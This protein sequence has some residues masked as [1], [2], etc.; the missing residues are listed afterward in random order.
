MKYISHKGGILHL[1]LALLLWVYGNGHVW[2]GSNRAT[3]AASPMFTL[4]IDAGHGGKDPGAIGKT[5][6]EKNINLSVALALGRLVEQ[7]CPDVRVVYT[8]KTDVFVPLDRR[9]EIANKAKADLFLSIHTNALPAGNRARGAETYTLGMARAAA[10]LEVAKRENAAILI[11]NDYEARY[12]GFDPKS[13]ESYIIFEF[14]QDKNMEQSVKLARYIQQEFRST[15]GRPDKGVHQAGFL[16]LRATSM[17]SALIELG[18]ISTPDEERYLNSAEGV[19]QMSRSIY[20]AFLKY[21]QNQKKGRTP[22]LTDSRKTNKRDGRNSSTVADTANPKEREPVDTPPQTNEPA[23][24][25]EHTPPNT[26]DGAQ[27][28]THDGEKNSGLPTT[29]NEPPV[30]KVQILTCDHK[31]PATDKRFKGLTGIEHYREKNLYK[32]TWGATTDYAECQRRRK[33]VND[34]FPDAFVIAFCGGERIDLQEA[35]R[36]YKQNQKH[37]P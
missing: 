21:R 22:A 20:N 5:S 32:F 9:A 27:A 36:M 15:A 34:K 2:G 26:S 14:M 8:R 35:I 25:T 18:Y 16:V 6:R 24:S 28:S 1:L 4:V 13:A 37:K 33:Q 31:L 11:E 19:R 23:E 29:G 17:P 3:P 7:N 30:F 12:Q 10:N